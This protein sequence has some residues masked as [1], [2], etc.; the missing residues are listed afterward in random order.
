VFYKN[1]EFNF[2]NCAMSIEWQYTRRSPVSRGSNVLTAAACVYMAKYIGASR[3]T[4]TAPPFEQRIVFLQQNEVLV[5]PEICIVFVECLMNLFLF[6]HDRIQVFELKKV[7]AEIVVNNLSDF[8]NKVQRQV[9][10]FEGIVDPPSA[11]AEFFCQLRKWHTTLTYS[12]F[13]DLSPV[14]HDAQR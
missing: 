8:R 1:Y 9:R 3:C 13:Y 12:F 2:A 6:Q 5:L 10:V 14:L 11:L 7:V 4:E